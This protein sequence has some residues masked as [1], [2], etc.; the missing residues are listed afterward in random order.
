MLYAISTGNLKSIRHRKQH[1]ERVERQGSPPTEE[2]CLKAT[3]EQR[4]SRL[5]RPVCRGFWFFCPAKE[6]NRE[7]YLKLL[8][9]KIKGKIDS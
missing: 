4:Q 5:L 8:Q 3:S 7:Y 1:S 9:S 6:H 2:C